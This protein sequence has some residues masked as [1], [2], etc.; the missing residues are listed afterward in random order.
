MFEDMAEINESLGRS[1]CTPEGCDEDEL[2]AELAMLQDEF[3]SEEIDA[4]QQAAFLKT[5]VVR[6]N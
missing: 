3:E 4:G 5:P 2:E 6:R 1:Y